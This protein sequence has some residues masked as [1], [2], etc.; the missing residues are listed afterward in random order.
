MAGLKE[1][2]AL[3][4]GIRREKASGRLRWRATAPGQD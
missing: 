3:V 1:G 4:T 2:K